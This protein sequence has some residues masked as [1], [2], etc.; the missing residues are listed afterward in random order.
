MLIWI[1]FTKTHLLREGEVT[2]EKIAVELGFSDSADL[3][4]AFRRWS[5]HSPSV[6]RS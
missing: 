5:G 1:I 4:R 2:I 3:R 6:S